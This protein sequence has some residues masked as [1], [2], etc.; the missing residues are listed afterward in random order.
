MKRPAHITWMVIAALAMVVAAG[1]YLVLFYTPPVRLPEALEGRPLLE[2]DGPEFHD[3]QIGLRF[4]P[5]AGWGMQAR[6]TESPTTHKP[7]RMVV[8]YKR[9]VRG[10]N[11]AWLRVH[12]VDAEDDRTPDELI[13]TRKPRENQWTVT[14]P[15]ESGLTIAGR[16]AARV[17]FGG[18]MDADGKGSRPCSAEVVAFR[19]GNRAFYFTGTYHNADTE[20]QKLLR[21]AM[22]TIKFTE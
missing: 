4:T 13:K 16:P 8:K 9:L 18:L 11:V 12:V 6:S 5:P 19:V 3:R 10:P 20:T 1:I 15:I 17:T 14:K 22:E 21:E 7:E 2:Q